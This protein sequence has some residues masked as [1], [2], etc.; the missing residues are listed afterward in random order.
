MLWRQLHA[1]F[2]VYAK[3]SLPHDT[4]ETWPL[5]AVSDDQY[6]N[7]AR[8]NYTIESFTIGKLHEESKCHQLYFDRY[9]QN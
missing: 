5:T 2:L 8:Q 4:D 3:S 7:A 6:N 1:K 9:I